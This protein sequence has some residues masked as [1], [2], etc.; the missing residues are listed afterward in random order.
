MLLTGGEPF[1]STTSAGLGL[2]DFRMGGVLPSG[3]FAESDIIITFNFYCDP[4]R[5]INTATLKSSI[6]VTICANGGFGNSCD[7]SLI[8]ANDRWFDPYVPATAGAPTQ[9]FVTTIN[10]A[11]PVELLRYFGATADPAYQWRES[12]YSV[13]SGTPLIGPVSS[14]IHGAKFSIYDDFITSGKGTRPFGLTGDTYLLKVV[15]SDNSSSWFPNTNTTKYTSLRW[16]GMN[17]DFIANPYQ[18]INGGTGPRR[19]WEFPG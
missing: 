9:G 6:P 18:Y 11:M 5:N 1:L 12:L 19:G 10:S 14:A 17:Q 3:S 8:Y 15:I 13:I 4:N 7:G 2:Y 16:M